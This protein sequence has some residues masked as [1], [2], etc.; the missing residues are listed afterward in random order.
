M[1]LAPALVCLK[2]VRRVDINMRLLPCMSLIVLVD[3]SL[4]SYATMDAIPVT[5]SAAPSLG[6][7]FLPWPLPVHE[8]ASC[9]NP[10]FS[11]FSP[12]FSFLHASYNE[13]AGFAVVESIGKMSVPIPG[14]F[15]IRVEDQ[16]RQGYARQIVGVTSSALLVDFYIPAL[17]SSII[18]SVS[19]HMVVID[20]AVWEQVK[21]LSQ[22]VVDLMDNFM[23]LNV[24]G[25]S[26]FFRII[27]Y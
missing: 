20:A 4:P 27:Y 7:C 5:T 17:A 26:P 22:Q 9:G 1:V 19:I 18:L 11:P 10:W 23:E 25:A 21:V 12:S 2:R 8:W 24:P 15:P 13:L 6:Y 14:Y 3:D 16:E